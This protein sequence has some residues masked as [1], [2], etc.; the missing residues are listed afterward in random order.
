MEKISLILI[1]T[2]RT[3]LTDTIM[4]MLQIQTKCRD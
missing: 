1:S 2:S 4:L 3:I